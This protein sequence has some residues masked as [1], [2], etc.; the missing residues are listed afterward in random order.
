MNY[1]S[2]G[3]VGG[4]GGG[5]GGVKPPFLLVEIIESHA[6]N[7]MEFHITLRRNFHHLKLS[8]PC[9]YYID[10]TIILWHAMYVPCITCFPLP[11]SML[12]ISRH[13][14]EQSARD[15]RLDWCTSHGNR[16]GCVH[17]VTMPIQPVWECAGC[18]YYEGHS[19]L[20]TTQ[21]GG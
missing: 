9:P 4:G 8:S 20:Q 3:G 13:N 6:W 2:L 15:R 12:Q 1:V 18:G 16:G 11:L 21:F 7:A 17:Y 10:P 5:G 19:C 14:I